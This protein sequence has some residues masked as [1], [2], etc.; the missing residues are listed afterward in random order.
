MSRSHF[1]DSGYSVIVPRYAAAPC[2]ESMPTIPRMAELRRRDLLRQALL[3]SAAVSLGGWPAGARA[4]PRFDRDPFSL[5]VASG[6]PTSDGMVLWTRLAPQ[7]LAPDGGMPPAAV[8][9]TWE[10]SQD[11][12]FHRIA[13]RGIAY[14]EAEWAHSVHVEVQGLEPG[15]EYW[16][17]FSAGE[18]RSRPGRTRTAPAQ[19]AALERLRIALASCQQYE[20][21]YYVAYRNIVADDPDLIVHV[22]DYIYELSWGRDSVRQHGSGECYT[23]ADYRVRH[24]LY[25]SDADLAAAHAAC[26]WFLTWDDHEV[27]NDY[28]GDSS[29]EADDPELFHARRA[30]AYR[31]Y[32]EHMPLPRRAAP[33]GAAMRLYASATFGSLL[34]LHLLDE[35]QYRS[36]LA[37]PKP[38]QAGSNRVR[39]EDCPAL[40][41]ESRSMLGERQEAW[42]GARLKGSRARWNLLGQGVVMAYVTEEPRPSRLFW[43][44]GWNGYQAAR[45]RLLRQVHDTRVSNPVVLS[46]DIHSF[47]AADLHL[48]P[49]DPTTPCVASELVT[50][51]ITSQPPTETMLRKYA[52]YNPNVLL[53]TGISRGYVRLDVSPQ[54]LRADLVAME[55]VRQRDSAARV[56]ASFAIESGRPGLKRA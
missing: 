15:R 28:A 56:L 47:V 18:A 42:L 36:P 10:L 26:P 21:G 20:H 44:D 14:A 51:S 1:V 22:G 5:G 25:R 2:L 9:V 3:A 17:R 27:D 53:A 24:A 23:L 32:Y 52:E 8:P 12:Q 11:E 30:A 41:D 16:Y 50:T 19:G 4:Q 55:T 7:P 37:C 49:A 54:A 46:G 33:A 45:A 43:T 6:Y 31:A 29:E 48:E 38:G 13:H 39:A 35:R 34:N 40:F